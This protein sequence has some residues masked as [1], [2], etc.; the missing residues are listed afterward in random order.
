MPVFDITQHYQSG[1]SQDFLVQSIRL[2]E[3]LA[4]TFSRSQA[5]YAKV[6]ASIV[7]RLTGSH[8]EAP[9][10]VDHNVVL[11]QNHGFS[12][13]A[14]SIEEAVYQAIFTQEAAKAQTT[15]L[16]AGSAHFRAKMNGKV[17]ESGNIKQASIESVED[18]HYLNAKQATDSWSTMRMSIDRPWQLWTREV[19][20][21]PLYENKLRKAS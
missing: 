16:T 3:A 11:M 6:G 13:A 17:D 15:A 10:D 21:S 9:T 2:G 18:V 19:E 5:T 1:D 14:S 4:A 12:T 7:N 8:T 20:V